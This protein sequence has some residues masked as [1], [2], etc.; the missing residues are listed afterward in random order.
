M[1]AVNDV[2]NSINVNQNPLEVLKTKQEVD[3]LN[4]AI[5]QNGK[6][7]VKDLGKDQF[8]Q[9]LLT[10]LKYQDPTSPMKDREFIGQMAQFSSLEQMLN[11]NK[12]MSK[13]L[14]NSTFQSSFDLLGHYVELETDKF[15]QSGNKVVLSG[16]VESVNRKGEDASITVNGEEYSVN[17]I[18][19]VSK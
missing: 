2:K 13:L 10:E 9:L 18:I 5:T 6:K 7:Q 8:I 11:F 16:V 12:G 3:Y 17:S 4:K 1:N 14:E 19:S 15:D